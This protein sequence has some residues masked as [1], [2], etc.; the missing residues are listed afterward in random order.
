MK[1]GVVKEIKNQEYRVG[2]T[3]A[4]VKELIKFNHQILVEAGAGLGSGFEDADYI[5]QGATI[6]ATVKEVYSSCD[7]IVKVKEPLPEEYG[8]LKKN[9]ILF[10]YLHL[11]AS[12]SLTQSLLASGVIGIAYETVEKSDGSLPLLIPMSEVAGKMAIQQGA[13]YLEKS[14][15]G[16]GVLLGGVIGV[17]PAMVLILG[18]G[19]VGINAA[20]MAAGL[21]A[22]VILMDN[23][24]ARLR[25]VAEYMPANVTTILSN[26]YNIE[27]YAYRADLIIGAVLIPGGKAPLLIKKEMLKNIKKG[28]VLIDVAVDQGGCIET[29]KVTSHDNPIYTL[30]GIVHYG[31]P[32]IPGA[33]PITSTMA[34]TGVT[35]PYLLQIAN[36]GWLKA[37]EDNN[38]LA[39]G[40]NIVNGKIVYPAIAKTF[41]LP[42]HDWKVA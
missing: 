1:I 22:N 3:P 35:L 13:K 34:L 36:K 37:C 19:I 41:G 33:V 7:L 5:Q 14:Q 28:T 24:I 9:Q 31:V 8:M 10:T 11:A 18:A 39:K 29:C 4:G 40:L 38:E 23:N 21:G 2:L 30:E 17:A 32:N 6:A 20:K 27:Q 26:E 12:E 16:R 42:L 25:Q 15:G